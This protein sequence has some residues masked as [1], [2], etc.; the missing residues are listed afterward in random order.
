MT[1][2]KIIEVDLC[3]IGASATGLFAVYEAGMLNLR[4]YVIDTVAMADVPLSQSEGDDEDLRNILLEKIMIFN[5]GFTR[6]ETIVR[7]ERSSADDYRV[8]TSGR[9]V[10]HC[11][12]IVLTETAEN[13]PS[14]SSGKLQSYLDQ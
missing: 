3:V 10:I 8:T 7:I 6:G 11:R 9:T 12:S 13:L 2:K 5:P 14:V 4:C 1:N